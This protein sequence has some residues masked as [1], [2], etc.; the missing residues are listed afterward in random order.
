M[1]GGAAFD[2]GGACDARGAALGVAR[3]GAVIGCFGAVGGARSTTGGGWEEIAAGGKFADFARVAGFAT[4]VFNSSSVSSVGPGANGA[5]GAG[6]GA[7]TG[8]GGGT[9][10]AGG[11]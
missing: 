3:G 5:T 2:V 8:R 10:A 4:H 7:W 9:A 1:I 11:A 6:A